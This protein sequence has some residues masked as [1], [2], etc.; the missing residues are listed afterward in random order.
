[1]FLEVR[2]SDKASPGVAR[3][4]TTEPDRIRREL[5]RTSLFVAIGLSLLFVVLLRL[6]GW[7]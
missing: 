2:S 1:L 4:R 5:M 6:S 7:L 3:A